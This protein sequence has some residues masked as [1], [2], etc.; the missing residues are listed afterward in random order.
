MSAEGEG[1]TL[2][3][4]LAGGTRA[5]Q[6][7]AL[8]ADLGAVNEDAGALVFEGQ[9]ARPMRVSVQ[10]RFGS[11]TEARWT[12]SVYLEPAPEEIRVPFASLRAAVGN[13]S[14]PPL[15]RASSVLFVVDLTNS[16]PGESGRF[17]IRRLHAETSQ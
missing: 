4:E 16:R 8:A 2:E 12:R 10:L 1:A 14:L 5:S 7:V 6:F 13:S 15:D 3:Y 17:T 11:E 9:A